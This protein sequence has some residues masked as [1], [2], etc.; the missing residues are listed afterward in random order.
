MVI[1]IFFNKQSCTKRF[2]FDTSIN[3]NHCTNCL[4]KAADRKTTASY[5]VTPALASLCAGHS[6]FPLQRRSV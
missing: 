3:L 5:I 2:R 6:I 4:K 1:I